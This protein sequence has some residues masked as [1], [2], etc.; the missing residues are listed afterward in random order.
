MWYVYVDIQEV[1]KREREK[2]GG[3]RE[4]ERCHVISHDI[5]HLISHDLTSSSVDNYIIYHF[6]P[7][8]TLSRITPLYTVQV[9]V[10]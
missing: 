4:E 1:G 8:H 9:H 10:P 5:Y 3:W 2:G 7:L 6:T